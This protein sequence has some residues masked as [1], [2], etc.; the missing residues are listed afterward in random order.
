MMGFKIL[1]VEDNESWQ[2]ELQED[3]SHALCDI[4]HPESTIELIEYFNKAYQALNESDWD[5]LVTDIGLGGSGESQQKRGI[6]LVKLAHKRQIPSIVV[7]GTPVVNNQDV[8]NLLKKFGASDYFSKPDFDD[9]MFIAKV[10]ELL[11]K[12][13]LDNQ[14]LPT[15]DL[16][17]GNS[18]EKMRD[19]FICHA[20]EDKQEVIEPLVDAF[21][22]TNISYWYDK[23]E[24]RWGDSITR[25]VNEGLSI[26]RFVIV[27][28]SK[29]FLLKN[30]PQR[31]LYSALNIEIYS[32]ETKVLP[33]IVIYNDE[34]KEYLFKRLPLLADK[35]YL[36]WNGN[37]NE[38]IDALQPHL[39][40]KNQQFD[41]IE[42]KESLLSSNENIPDKSKQQSFQTQPPG[43]LID[44]AI[45]T[46]I[47]VERQA[48]CKAL[49]LTDENRVK[50]ETRVY[51][52]G[53]LNFKDGEFYEIVV[54]Q[55]LDMAN[56]DAALLTSDT[57][58][59][60]HPESM[61]MVAI[62]GAASEE[63]KSGDLILGSNIYYYQ[64]G[65]ET[66]GGNKPEP[67]MYPSDATLWSRIISLPKWTARIS[68]KRPDGTK[69]RPKIFQ[70]VIASGERVIADAAVRDEIKSGQRKIRAIEM[71]GYGFSKAAWQSYNRV[72]HLVI[73]A[74]CDS[75]DPNKNDEWHL[76][77]ASVAA[78]FTKHFLSDRPLDPRNSPKS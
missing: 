44:F 49:G 41:S 26:S 78:E 35:A 54:A 77:A 48:V 4:G 42:D 53:R 64:R 68:V 37:P 59:H 16:V 1:L 3:I 17:T 24:I 5:L 28:L 72:R 76:Y 18:E 50:K 14:V 30:F 32:A 75:A 15:K 29:A 21:N 47:E 2:D 56:V 27:V 33:L 12:D 69:E 31:E 46:A 51:W 45:I 6:Q 40:K 36:K 19:V 71:E 70:G 62:A 13:H 38:I 63:E 57:I 74:I 61:L 39:V 34:E 43:F 73:R 7:S 67:Y 60:W 65:K 23:A 25:K 66:P 52:Q 9:E 10:K 8:R 22:K 11:Q 20:S 55:S 58:H